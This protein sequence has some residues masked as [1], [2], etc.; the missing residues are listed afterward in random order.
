M[1]KKIFLFI[2]RLMDKKL[3]LAL[4]E[5]ITCGLAAHQLATMPG[6]AEVLKGGVICYTEEV[7][8]TLL[9]VPQKLIDKHTAES[10]QVTEAI[11]RNLKKIIK[12]DICAGITGLASAGGSEAKTKPVG[13][14][15]YCFTFR[16]KIYKKRKV[17]KGT[18]LEI[19]K[20]ACNGLYKFIS[21]KVLLSN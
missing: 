11:A 12:A 3:T 21:E 1:D 6:T 16:N 4:A 8:T 19:R 20:K 13:T 5:S 10:M 17:F 18:P 2:K 15:F 14:V 7:K 9:K